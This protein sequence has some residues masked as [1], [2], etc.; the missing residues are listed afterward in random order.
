MLFHFGK[1]EKGKKMKRV[2]NFIIRL[3]N[4]KLQTFLLLIFHCLFF[5]SY[6]QDLHFSQFMNNPLLTNPANTGFNPD[7]NYRIGAS[8]RDQWTSLPVPYKTFS[9][10]GDAQVFKDRFENGWMGLGGVLLNDV[11]GAGNLT[12]T[13]GYASIA[14]HQELGY[15][16]LLSGG[17][18]VGFVSKSVDLSKLTFANQWTGEFF[19]ANYTSGESFAYSRIAYMD[20]QIGLNYAY[21]ASDNLYLNAGV[22]LMH[23]N[24]PK[25][26]FFSDSAN[27]NTVPQRFTMFGNA[28]IKVDPNWIINPNAYV[29]I[30]NKASEI[31]LGLNAQYNLS[32][33]GDKQLIG[34]VYYRVGDAAVAMIGIELHKVRF[35][36]TYDATTSMLSSYNSGNGATEFSAIKYGNYGNNAGLSETRCPSFVQ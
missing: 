3:K 15:K 17:F 8:Y 4:R 28:S 20:M 13:K 1:I 7:Y 21:F 16:S 19:D 30:Q 36:F 18:N 34:G 10:W 22:S 25:E 6:S 29:S 26:S 14:Y 11:A 31:M 9:I 27:N 2:F 35:T 23:L 32:G 5:I 24:S 33:D 12:S